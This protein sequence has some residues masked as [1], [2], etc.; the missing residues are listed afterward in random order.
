MEGPNYFDQF[1]T[2]VAEGS[3]FETVLRGHL[4]VEAELLRSLRAALPFP[5]R[6]EL[7]R[8]PFIQKASLVSA[9]GLMAADEPPGYR[10]L[11]GLRNKLAHRV[12]AELTRQDELDLVN[13][14]GER[15]R[16]LLT[17]LREN[18]MPQDFPH[19]LRYAITSMCIQLQVDRQRMALANVRLR[20]SAQ[21]LLKA[22]DRHAEEDSGSH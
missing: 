2:D 7:D 11:N 10:R 6:G 16:G 17:T 15:H 19:R 4:W 21:R 13:A 22:A 18:E 5:D 9:L 3:A 14:L 8:L 12:D 1:F 20:R